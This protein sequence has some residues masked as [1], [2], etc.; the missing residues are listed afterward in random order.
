MIENEAIE[1]FN[2]RLTVDLNNIKKMT[3][4]QLDRV[5]DLGSQAENLLKNKDFAYFVHSFK[6]DRVDVLTEIVGHS[7]IDN[8]MRVAISNQLAGIDE[9]IKSLKRAVYFK[10]RVVSHQTGQVTAEDPIA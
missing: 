1:A 6:F 9:F 4:G 10:N 5:K 3:P 7:E 8:N 2:K